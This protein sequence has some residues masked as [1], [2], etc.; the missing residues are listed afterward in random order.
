MFRQVTIPLA[1]LLALAGCGGDGTNP[2]TTDDPDDG[3]PDDTA[4]ITIPDSV[5]GDV[6]SLD[7]N[8][9]NQ[10][11]TVN[12]VTLDELPFQAAYTRQPGLDAAFGGYQVYTAQEDAL[13]RHST[14]L[15][16][17]SQGNA[18]SGRVRAGTVVTGG[19]RNRYFGGT[20]Y[21]RDGEY[22]PP[23]VNAT[24]G[25]VSYVG[26][27]VGLTNIAVR[28]GMVMPVDPSTP[29][30]VTP[31]RAAQVTGDML[32]NADFADNSV[33]GNIYN[34]QIVPT[35]QALPSLV[36]VATD[37]EGNGTF[38]GDIEYDV[39][40]TNPFYAGLD[41]AIDNDIGDY[42][43]IFGGTNAASVGGG[44][45]LEQIDGPDDRLGYDG[46][47]EYGTFVLEQCGTAGASS[48][49]CAQVN[50]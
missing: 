2:F 29:I 36:L 44:V 24:S 26:T 45:R 18:S 5:A 39:E 46:E 20:Y 38:S 15:L 17:Q 19:P 4:T 49:L 14:A 11:L 32:V 33:E 43:G 48:A 16:L 35:G 22:T 8:A 27:Y 1:L 23:A 47:E 28:D 41:P 40:Q 9:A 34:R 6:T 10:T 3:G 31:Y 12:G 37:I 7:Y 42:A 25:M 21:E 13:D 30:E 50:P